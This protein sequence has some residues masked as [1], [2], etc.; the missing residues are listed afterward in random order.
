M[1]QFL[2][3][4]LSTPQG[5]KAMMICVLNSNSQYKYLINNLQYFCNSRKKVEYQPSF[6]CVKQNAFDILNADCVL[7]DSKIAM[8]GATRRSTDSHVLN[9]FVNVG[10]VSKLVVI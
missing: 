3:V 8:Y 4:P 7:K 5:I 2:S 1:C 10:V 9:S 6:L